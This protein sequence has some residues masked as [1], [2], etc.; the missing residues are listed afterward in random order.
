MHVRLLKVLNW[1][2]ILVLNKIFDISLSSDFQQTDSYWQHSSIRDNANSKLP[3][4]RQPPSLAN[5][6]HSA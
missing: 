1:N 2:I 3:M 4:D 5:T 6:L